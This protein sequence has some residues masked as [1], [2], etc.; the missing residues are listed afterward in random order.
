[1]SLSLDF[2]KKIL[3]ELCA[4]LFFTNYESWEMHLEFFAR[5]KLF[6]FPPQRLFPHRPIL[7]LS[8]PSLASYVQKIDTALKAH[9]INDLMC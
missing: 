9:V 7:L 4:A 5:L 6:A 1:M 2:K 3:Q 8:T